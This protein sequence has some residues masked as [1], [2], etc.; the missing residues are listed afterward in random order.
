MDKDTAQNKFAHLFS[1]LV[2]ENIQVNIELAKVQELL[3]KKLVLSQD[4]K[5]SIQTSI[6]K[7][8]T[9]IKEQLEF[10]KTLAKKQNDTTK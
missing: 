7:R 1:S 9:K 8:T 2:V 3:L 10:L 6:N 5:D 4:E